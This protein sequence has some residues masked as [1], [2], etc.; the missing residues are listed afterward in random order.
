MNF[1]VND[2]DVDEGWLVDDKCALY[3]KF[4]VSDD[5][6]SEEHQSPP[7][8]AAGLSDAEDSD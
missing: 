5:E 6:D 4:E 7:G 2:C 8:A 3:D 1:L